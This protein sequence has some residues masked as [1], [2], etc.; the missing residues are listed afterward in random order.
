MKIDFPRCVLFLVAILS[1]IIV[2]IWGQ[3]L[4]HGNNNAVSLIVTFFSVL[5]GFL[6]GLIALITDP[7]KVATLGNWRITERYRVIVVQRLARQRWMF[8]LYLVTIALAFSS[9]LLKE[10]EYSI[11]IE[12]TYFA[13]AVT[14]F[15]LSLRLPW[16]IATMQME[17]Y[18][19]VLKQQRR[20]A[21]I[22]TPHPSENT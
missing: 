20:D 18:D 10:Y 22:R 6:V 17:R 12:R 11:F 1:G 3:P 16:T 14:S 2:F 7:S 8:V 21:G 5:A 13:L 9:T 19:A 15:I 4:I